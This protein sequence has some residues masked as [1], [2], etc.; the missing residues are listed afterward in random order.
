MSTISRCFLNAFFLL[1]CLESPPPKE[2]VN[3]WSITL[4]VPLT[5]ILIALINM[6]N[7]VFINVL[8]QKLWGIGSEIT[9][10]ISFV[11]NLCVLNVSLHLIHQSWKGD[12]NIISLTISTHHLTIFYWAFVFHCPFPGDMNNSR[13]CY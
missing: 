5:S 3:Q 7:F 12:V 8:F 4:C 10:L 11:H 6:F 2:V 9:Q 1:T 13:S